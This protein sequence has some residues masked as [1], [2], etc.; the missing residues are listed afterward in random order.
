MF[1]ASNDKERLRPLSRNQLF[2]SAQSIH[3]H[4]LIE[5]S[6][7]FLDKHMWPNPAALISSLDGLGAYLPVGLLRRRSISKEMAQS[8]LSPEC[9][10]P[11]LQRSQPRGETGGK[12]KLH[13]I[14]C[15]KLA[16]IVKLR[17]PVPGCGPV[18]LGL[19]RMQPTV[20]M[21]GPVLKGPR[22]RD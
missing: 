22:S 16:A 17:I 11:H 10:D 6:T 9:R 1:W 3:H 15:G 8:L 20:E 13:Y 14:K 5:Y 2:P 18:S 4:L 21:K 7:C 12:R 19:R